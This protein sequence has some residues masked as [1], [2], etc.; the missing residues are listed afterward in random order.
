MNRTRDDINNLRD[1]IRDIEGWKAEVR[2]RE[3][4]ARF[5]ESL[6]T[7]GYV[8]GATP[9]NLD[10]LLTL[11]P[12]LKRFLTQGGKWRWSDIHKAAEAV[13]G[14]DLAIEFERPEGAIK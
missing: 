3:L 13:R 2:G 10:D 6:A 8:G 9:S 12:A 5:N 4:L 11:E 7:G 1:R 14:A